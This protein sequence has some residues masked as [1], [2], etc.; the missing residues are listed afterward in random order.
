MYFSPG[1]S[2][3]YLRQKR[4]RNGDPK[5][6]GTIGPLTL[7]TA[8]ALHSWKRRPLCTRTTPRALS[9][10]LPGMASTMSGQ[11]R[12]IRDVG[13]ATC[14][15]ATFVCPRRMHVCPWELPLFQASGVSSTRQV[16][17]SPPRNSSKLVNTP[18]GTL[19]LLLRSPVRRLSSAA[20]HYR[21]SCARCLLLLLLDVVVSDHYATSQHDKPD[22]MPVSKA[23]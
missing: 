14:F 1:S 23:P 9:L 22:F 5:D 20:R 4:V 6:D 2:T 3:C 7:C 16:P 11:L 10:C 13:A 8:R 17:K 12:D 19:L 18:A 15:L 21:I